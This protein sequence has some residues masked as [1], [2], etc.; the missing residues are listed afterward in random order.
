V[1]GAVA[2]QAAG[3]AAASAVGAAAGPVGWVVSGAMS[4]GLGISEIVNAVKERK[5]RK[6]FSRTVN[7]VLEQFGIPKPK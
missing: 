2:G 1:V 6:A 3:A 5:E 4:I 7:P